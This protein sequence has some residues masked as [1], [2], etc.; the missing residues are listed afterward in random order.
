MN[1]SQKKVA[2]GAASGV[3]TMAL[4][5]YLLYSLLPEIQGV[6]S[7]A[8]RLAFTLR[9]NVVAVIPFFIMMIFV[10]NGRFLSDAI[11]P[12]KHLETKALEINGR[13]A[14]N[15]LQQT[16][17]FFV[18]TLALSTFLTAT[19]IKLIVALTI[20]F[21]IA[22]TVFWI[23]YRIDPLY[24]APGMAATSYMNLGILLSVLYLI[25]M[26]Q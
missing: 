23:G 1:Q 3:A 13:V 9:M 22:R 12:T 6:T 24:R 16:F 2:I 19:S 18:G 15:T 10:G 20:V 25:I 8:E 26:G 11:D 5:V 7:L 21:L 4:S 17:V 14:D